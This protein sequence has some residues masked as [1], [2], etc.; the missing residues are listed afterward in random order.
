MPS[1]IAQKADRTNFVLSCTT[2][3]SLYDCTKFVRT[4]FR[5]HN[6]QVGLRLLQSKGRGRSTGQTARA[7]RAHSTGTQVC[8]VRSVKRATAEPA[9]HARVR[10]HR[11]PR[12]SAARS[13]RA[14]LRRHPRNATGSGVLHPRSVGGELRMRSAHAAGIAVALARGPR[15]AVTSPIGRVTA[16]HGS[17]PDL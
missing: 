9:A 8:V 14:R 5:G 7:H 17:N 10:V 12:A 6:P 11:P 16:A 4:A 1:K 13:P 2:V 15:A 3:Q